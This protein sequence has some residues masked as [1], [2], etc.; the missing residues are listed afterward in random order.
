M[1]GQAD[2]RAIPDRL[3]EVRARLKELEAEE[4]ALREVLLGDPS[5]REGSEWLATVVNQVAR[6]VR[7][8]SLKGAD[9]E[10]WERLAVNVTRRQVRLRRR[11]EPEGVGE[12]PAPL[13]AA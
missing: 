2:Q 3:A 6:L 7:S 5:A 1:S 10:L 4:E 8:S 12:E 11:G 13:E 9:P